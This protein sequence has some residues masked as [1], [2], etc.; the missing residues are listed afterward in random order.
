MTKIKTSG[1][2]K[3]R[4]D[5]AKIVIVSP[6]ET[7]DERANMAMLSRSSL[8]NYIA[9]LAALSVLFCTLSVL[10]ILTGSSDVHYTKIMVYVKN[11]FD[12]SQP[13]N[14]TQQI[15]ILSEIRRNP[16]ALSDEFIQQVNDKAD[17]WEAGRNFPTSTSMRVLRRMMGVKEEP[18]F[19]G[20]SS[21]H[22]LPLKVYSGNIS[23]LPA[24]FDAR[25]QWPDCPSLREIRDQ[26]GCGSCWAFGAVEAMTDRHCIVHKTQFHYSAEDVLSCCLNCGAGCSGGFPSEAFS[27][28]RDEGIVSGGNFDSKSGCMPYEVPSCEHYIDDPRPNCEDA[29]TPECSHSCIPEYNSSYA[30]DKHFAS[31]VYYVESEDQA[32]KDLVEHGPLVATFDVYED[33]LSYKSGVYY[34]VHG[35][36]LGSH[37]VKLIGYG[38]ENDIPYYLCANSWN[39]DWGDNGFFKIS[40][41]E[42]IGNMYSGLP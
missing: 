22:K 13:P 18:Q 12:V 4:A 25:L 7:A 37:A 20:S 9:L 32:L 1:D 33:F 23:G 10:F 14:S 31:Q 3:H 35:D 41:N 27:F 42:I 36:C 6:A 8:K 11:Y 2:Q 17:H 39:S 28:W 26:G 24:E 15:S 34:H 30:N 29:Y 21:A 19:Q 16:H 5:E 40:R 38:V